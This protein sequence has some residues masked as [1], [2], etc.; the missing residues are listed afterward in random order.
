M[1]PA[2]R[3]R[4]RALP[5]GRVVGEPEAEVV[6][7]RKARGDRLAGRERKLGPVG[8]PEDQQVI[9]LEDVL[10]ET[11]VLAV[12]RGRPLEIRDGQRDVV[13]RHRPSIAARRAD[14]RVADGVYAPT[15]AL[16]CWARNWCTKATAM[17][18]SPTAAATRFTGPERTSPHANTPGTLVSSR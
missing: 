14:A 2:A 15:R 1:T 9:I 4:S 6:R 7:A 3:K 11:E 10:G 13:E 5:H 17:L 16:S 8:R 18:P 12:E